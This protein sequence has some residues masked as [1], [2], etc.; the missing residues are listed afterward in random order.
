MKVDKDVLIKKYH[1]D[2]LDQHELR[3][4]EEYIENGIITLDDLEDIH[5]MDLKLD[6]I[7]VPEPSQKLDESFYRFLKGANR[8]REAVGF[9]LSDLWRSG[10]LVRWAYSIA[11]VGIGLAAGWLIKGEGNA[12]SEV[13]KLSA[14]VQEMKEL[15]MLTLLEK[16]STSDRLK[17]VSLT[18]EIPEVSDKVTDALLKTLNNDDNVNVR[19]AALEALYPYAGDPKVR[20]GLIAS[21]TL[22]ESPLVQVGLAEMMVAL[23]EKQS[24]SSLRKLLDD[25]TTPPEIKKQIKESIEILI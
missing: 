18:N 13:N 9:R 12:H 8:E 1:Q 11:L 2:S 14:E 15:M 24:V 22:Q 16:E 10:P 21:I 23:Q 19:L 5:G 7:P 6:A 25:E 20:R 4:L 3:W 17:A